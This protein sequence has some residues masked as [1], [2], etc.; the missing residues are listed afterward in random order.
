M[1]TLVA[2]LTIAAAY[3]LTTSG[4]FAQTY[5]PDHPVC[6][7]VYGLTTYYECGYNSMAQ[8]NQTAAGRAAQCV[9]NPYMANA[10][11]RGFP[12]RRRAY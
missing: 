6:L 1:K 5:A 11:M 4:A 7:H 9:P 2:L 3:A 10:G 12:V 8:C